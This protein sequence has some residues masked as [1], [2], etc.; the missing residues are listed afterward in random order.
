MVAN[1]FL[2]N[3][4]RSCLPIETLLDLNMNEI[5]TKTDKEVFDFVIRKLNEFVND[6]GFY[7]HEDGELRILTLNLI[8]ADRCFFFEN[9]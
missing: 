2:V 4:N 8:Q 3:Q 1:K 6:K 5:G 7:V 9:D